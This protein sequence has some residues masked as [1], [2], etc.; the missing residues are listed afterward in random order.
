MKSVITL[1]LVLILCTTT[2]SGDLIH[3]HVS[4]VY[5]GD[6]VLVKTDRGELRVRLYGIDAPE[7]DQPYNPESTAYPTQLVANKRIGIYSVCLVRYKRYLAKIFQDSWYINL[8]IVRSGHAWAYS[9]G[10]QNF[11]LKDAQELAKKR[12]IGLWLQPSP[13]APWKYRYS[14]R[15]PPLQQVNKSQVEKSIQAELRY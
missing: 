12:S 1:T 5:D 13:T 8:A 3:G 6:T 14:Q 9:A 10:K 7:H 15:A 2:F 4:E 11:E